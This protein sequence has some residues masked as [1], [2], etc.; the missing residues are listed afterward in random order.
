MSNSSSA[1]AK[2]LELITFILEVIFQQDW[3]TFRSTVLSNPAYFKSVSRAISNLPEFNGMTLLHAMARYNPPL[4]VVAL[5]IE[6]CPDLPAAKD[7]LGRTPLHVAAGSGAR[8]NLIKLIAHACPSSCVAQDEDLKTP[9]HYAC[10]SS[11]VLFEG[12]DDKSGRQVCHD[13]IRALLSES[14]DAA[15]IEDIDEM[16]P[17]EYAILSDAGLNTVKILQKASCKTLQSR[18]RSTSPIPVRAGH[19]GKE[20]QTKTKVMVPSISI[21]SIECT[22]A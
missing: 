14:L 13:S 12:D 1:K 4:D 10:D 17:L 6:I 18:S 8:P 7:C 2:V 3:E 11:C 22:R 20:L 5:M 15:T 19:E 16:N 9:L 21:D